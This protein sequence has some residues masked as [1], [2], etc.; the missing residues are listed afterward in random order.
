MAVRP[1]LQYVRN[2]VRVDERE[3]ALA[4]IAARTAELRR[5]DGRAG[6]GPR[7]S[8]LGGDIIASSLPRVAAIGERVR[9]LLEELAS[10]RVEPLFDPIRR[11][12]VQIY[13]EPED[14][15]RWHFDAHDFAA[16]VTLENFSDAVTEL[17]APNVSSLVRPLFYPAYAV[18]QI[19]SLLPRTTIAAEAGDA[20]LFTGSR[21]LHR[22][23]S[24]ATGRRTILVFAFDVAGRR[25]SHLRNRLA[26]L[27]NY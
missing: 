11:A 22:G 25:R 19:F 27:V 1:I 17:I 2:Y 23:R 3:A 26:R 12:R 9:T 24:R 6:I 13:T 4:E 10:T 16:V 5:I 20:L 15:F 18:P 7:Y 8:V 14:G 21:S